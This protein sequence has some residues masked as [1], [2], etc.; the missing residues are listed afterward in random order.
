MRTLL[1]G[2]LFIRL[3]EVRCTT[4]PSSLSSERHLS[5]F[6]IQTMCSPS[7]TAC[8]LSFPFDIRHRILTYNELIY[9]T[10]IYILFMYLLHVRALLRM[11]G[12]LSNFLSWDQQA[13]TVLSHLF[14]P[15][16]MLPSRL[17]Q[18]FGLLSSLIVPHRPAISF[19]LRPA[20]AFSTAGRPPIPLARRPYTTSLPHT[21]PILEDSSSASSSPLTTTS[22][23]QP[24]PEKLEPRLSM[25]FTCT[26]DGCGERSTHQFTKRSYERGIVL[27]ECPGCKNRWVPS[28]LLRLGSDS[29]GGNVVDI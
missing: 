1:L 13:T 5:L 19:Q 28:F 25:T 3:V 26:V 20:A 23:S 27:V 12:H 7:N 11:P 18:N 9:S 4:Y 16:N 6:V 8:S 24:L 15:N 2:L 10:Y 21:E 29:Q 22:P 14:L 17:F